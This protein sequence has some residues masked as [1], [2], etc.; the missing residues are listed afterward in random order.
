MAHRKRQPA[1]GLF[2]QHALSL[3]IGAIVVLWL[4]LYIRGDHLTHLG[5]FYGN[6]VAD[7]TGTLL[8]VIATK[9]FAEQGSKESRKPHHRGHSVVRYFLEC[10]SLT[11]VL[12][13]TGAAWAVAYARGDANSKTGQV[14][15][16]LVSEWTQVLG[17]VVITKYAREIGST[18][19]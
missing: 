6:A 9:Y 3:I 12:V 19:S 8:I 13:I 16:N 18:E 17:L 7:W 1:P 14:V 4:I 11:I 2:R 10:H 5:A 15:G